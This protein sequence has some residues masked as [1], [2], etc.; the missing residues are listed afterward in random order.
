[1]LPVHIVALW[2]YLKAKTQARGSWDEAGSAVEKVILTAIF[3]R[4]GHRRWSHHRLQ[5]HG[6]GLFHQPELMRRATSVG[7]SWLGDSLG[8]ATGDPSSLCCCCSW[9][10]S[11]HSG[12]M[13][14]RSFTR[15]LRRATHRLARTVEEINWGEALVE[16][17]LQASQS[18][19]IGPTVQVTRSAGDEVTVTG[20]GE[21]RWSIF[22]AIQFPSLSHWMPD[23]SKEFRAGE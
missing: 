19:V 17:V 11:W 22:P 7:R 9:R 13:H 5:G 2:A 4:T 20:D 16:E 1:M 14:H 18:N 12:L 3:G 10:C 15:P 23:Q 6:S 21:E 8:G